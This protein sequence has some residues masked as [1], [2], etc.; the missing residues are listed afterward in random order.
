M[1]SISELALQEAALKALAEIVKQQLDTTKAA[2][3]AE[4][5]ASGVG[6]VDASLPDG[7]KVA[8]ITKTNPKP[9]PHIVDE[10]AFLNWARA[11]SEDNI[12][13][14]LVTEVRPAYRDALLKQM[15]KHGAPH[16]VNEDGEIIDVPGVEMRERPSYHSVKHTDGALDAIA[17]AWRNRALPLPEI[18]NGSE[19]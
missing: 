17:T 16:I 10:Q 14:R 2:M 9:A 8:T 11:Q 15:T 6:R 7:V 4:L 12:V 3:Q 13:T 19:S 18:T 5:E 1:P